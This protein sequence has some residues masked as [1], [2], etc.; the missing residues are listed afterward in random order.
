[1]ENAGHSRA[2]NR[3][4]WDYPEL[5]KE[6]LDVGSRHA[7]VFGELKRLLAIRARQKAFHPNATQFTLHLG[8]QVFAFWRQSMDR[9]QSIFCISNISDEEQKIL[10]SRVNLINTED[11]FDLI[12]SQMVDLNAEYLTLKPYQSVWISNY[13]K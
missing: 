1:M 12:D 5:E 9:R 10:L 3:H 7:R 11:W 4:Q 2:I 6:L 13:N 8:E